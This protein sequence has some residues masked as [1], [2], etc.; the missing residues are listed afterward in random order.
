VR[1]SGRSACDGSQKELHYGGA[2]H[3]FQPTVEPV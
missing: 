1:A 3:P 2:M